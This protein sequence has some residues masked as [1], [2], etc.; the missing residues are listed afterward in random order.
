MVFA[1]RVAGPLVRVL[2]MVDVEKK[3]ETGYIYEAMDRTKKATV[4]SFKNAESK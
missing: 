4:K 2:R 3:S 1:L